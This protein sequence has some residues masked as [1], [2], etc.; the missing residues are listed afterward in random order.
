MGSNYLGAQS[1]L[2]GGQGGAIGCG[3]TG[4]PESKWGMPSVKCK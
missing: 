2:G 4:A 3:G 1:E